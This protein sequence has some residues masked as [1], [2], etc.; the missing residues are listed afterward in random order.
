MNVTGYEQRA[1]LL[2]WAEALAALVEPRDAGT[3]KSVRQAAAAYSEHRFVL[4][5]LGKAKRGKSTLVNAILGR[6][7]DELAPIDKLPASSVLSRF[8]SS[9][10][11]K[12]TVYYRTN[13]AAGVGQQAIDPKQIRQFVTE[14]ENPGNRKLVD[15]VEVAGP[16][17]GFDRDLVL[18]DT[19]GAGSIHEYHDQIV[20]AVI[21][22]SDAVIFLVTARMPLDQDELALLRQLREADVRKVIFAIN[23]VDQATAEELEQAETHN[24][25]LLQQVGIA[26]DHLHRI[27]AKQAFEGRQAESGLDPLLNEIRGFLTEGKAKTLGERLASRVRNAVAPLLQGLNAELSLAGQT[28]EE[29]EQTRRELERQRTT[30]PTQR[31]HAER[32][33]Q[34]VWQH[35]L[36]EFGVQ[37]RGARGAVEQQLLDAIDQVSLASVG[38]LT[39]ELPTRI[40]ESIEAS[41]R[42]YALAA[43]EALQAACRELEATYPRL[44]WDSTG[45]LS[46]MRADSQTTATGAAVGTAVAVAG[47]GLI[48][49]AQA[50][51]VA[52]VTYVTTPSLLGAALMFYTGTAANLVTTTAVPMTIPIWAAAAGPIGWTLIGLGA[53]AVPVAWSLG[54]AKMKD[55]LRQQTQQQVERVY[56]FLLDERLPLIRNISESILDEFRQRGDRELAEIESA[57]LRAESCPLDEEHKQQLATTRNQLAALLA[58]EV[59]PA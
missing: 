29:R 2:E 55:Q 42:P 38:T 36:D 31:T 1:Q 39:K 30:L 25:A 37:V 4:T 19:P 46:G 40:T 35:V 57:L 12:A 24:R 56:Q 10:S 26:V 51:A 18:I 47:G 9:E 23:R 22:Q 5:V 15:C 52:S 13:A 3:A 17:P 14:E 28:G 6:R 49:A 21:P 53:L 7:D 20:R 48:F 16:F 33:F 41:V 59:T 8:V 45:P 43:E 32:R 44:T 11:L 27:S 58:T 50:A 34:S 54:R